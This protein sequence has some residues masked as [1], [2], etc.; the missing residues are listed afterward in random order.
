MQPY[1]INEVL[2]TTLNTTVFSL[3]NFIPRFISGLIVLL[4]G[5]IIGTFVKQ[6]ITELFRFVRFEGLLKRYGVPESKDSMTWS[7]IIGE[8]LRWF[9]IILFLVP[10]ADLWGL[11]KFTDVL[12]GLLRYLPNVF[13]AV[14]LLLI[15]FVVAKL[16]YDLILTSITGISKDTAKTIASVAR[17]SILIFVFLAV[18]NQLGIASDLI[19]ILFAGFVAMIALAGG[20]AFGLGGKDVAADF[21]ERFVSAHFLPRKKQ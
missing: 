6:L 8:L 7:N 15:G 21:L 20:L 4:L 16:A 14:L 18:L 12:N 5:I 1:N 13:V 19:R 10:T 11:N 2:T 17:W 9:V 3:A